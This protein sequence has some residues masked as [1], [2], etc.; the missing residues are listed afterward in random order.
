MTASAV[1]PAFEM[2]QVTHARA[3]LG[4]DAS[5]PLVD[6]QQAAYGQSL[7]IDPTTGLASLAR[8]DTP[9]Q[10]AG[11]AANMS[12]R[13]DIGA[14]S[15]GGRVLVSWGTIE[16][17]VGSTLASDNF[18]IADMGTPWWYAGP[19]T[20]GKLT[21]T[22]TSAGSNLVNRSMGGI[23]LSLDP[24][25]P[26]GGPAIPRV[27]EGPVAQLVGRGAMIANAFALASTGIADAAAS[28][29]I[30]EKPVSHRPKVHG[31][32]ADITF[33]GVAVTA[34]NTDYAVVTFTKRDAAGGQPVVLG[35]YDTRITG[36]GAVT[37]FVPAAFSLSA[38]AGALNLLENDGVTITVT[39]G[40][41]GQVLTGG[42]LINGKAI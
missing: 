16:G 27:W 18:T 32:V 36:Q 7:T 41:A 1:D 5:I 25:S 42:F 11:G 39:K 9:N 20:P 38:V 28:T 12:E 35:T 3:A 24:R 31:V 14:N 8:D 2:E 4:A 29:T 17:R 33:S 30:A 15:G 13:S 23:V 34:S 26:I 6:A 21:H 37:A 22:G 19:K 40:G 10:I